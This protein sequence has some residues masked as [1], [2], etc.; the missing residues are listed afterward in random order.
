V[1]HRSLAA[2]L[3]L[4]AITT[5]YFTTCYV[6]GALKLQNLRSRDVL[7]YKS[8]VL[9][10]VHNILILRQSLAYECSVPIYRARVFGNPLQVLLKHRLFHG[11]VESAQTALKG[12]GRARPKMQKTASAMKLTASGPH[13]IVRKHPSGGFSLALYGRT[14]S[15]Y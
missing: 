5:Y 6:S 9:G 11:C 13:R 7:T 14:H 10:I 15:R 4:H 1:R 3:S 12:D 8:G 2:Q